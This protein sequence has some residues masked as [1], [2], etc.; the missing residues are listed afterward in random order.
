MNTQPVPV[1]RDPSA[2]GIPVG[3]PRSMARNSTVTAD[4]G[5]GARCGAAGA[6]GPCSAVRVFE[7]GTAW[8]K[9]IDCNFA[10]FP[11]GV[12]CRA[13][14][15]PIMYDNQTVFLAASQSI[16]AVLGTDDE[17]RA[18]YNFSVQWL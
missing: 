9:P 1:G 14:V 18:L 7:H 6:P 10:P 5:F 15:G 12:D 8:A 11:K 13:K 3:T 17:R 4:A 2:K 16:A